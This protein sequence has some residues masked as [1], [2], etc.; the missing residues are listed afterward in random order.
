[1][2][3]CPHCHQSIDH[4]GIEVDVGAR[5]IIIDSVAYSCGTPSHA[6]LLS[7]FAKRLGRL[8]TRE[9]AHT[10]MYGHLPECDQPDLKVIDVYIVHIR[11]HLKAQE[12]PLEL[13][14]QWGQGFILRKK[15]VPDDNAVTM[16]A[17]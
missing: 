9:S 6:R 1:M 2:N 10:V 11:R 13:I 3:I 14:T 7:V 16:L 17:S 4:I 12:C 8:V 15:T 5:A